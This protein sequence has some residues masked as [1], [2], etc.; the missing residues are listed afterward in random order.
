M[1]TSSRP[2]HPCSEAGATTCYSREV[3]SD[4]TRVGKKIPPRHDRVDKP[5]CLHS[6]AARC[7]PACRGLRLQPHCSK[8]L[9]AAWTM[10]QHY[11]FLCPYGTLWCNHAPALLRTIWPACPSSSGLTVIEEEHGLSAACS[12]APTSIDET[13]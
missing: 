3:G 5:R 7:C 12:A 13:A 2:R 9:L 8:C 6:G 4:T 1:H 10:Y 11:H